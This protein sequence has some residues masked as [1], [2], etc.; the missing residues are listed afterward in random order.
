MK[1]KFDNV[2]L[3]TVLGALA[4]AITVFFI[5]RFIYPLEHLQTYYQNMWIYIVAPKVIS[6]G[7]IP[8]LGLFFLFI[9]SDRYKSAKGV[10]G[11]T[12]AYAIL[13]FILK[14]AN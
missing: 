3:G 8:N 14:L 9:Y 2:W 13:V 5:V 10:L 7:V 4:P 11:I 1:S 12:I 6:L